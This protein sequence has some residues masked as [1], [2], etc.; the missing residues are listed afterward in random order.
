MLMFLASSGGQEI[1]IGKETSRVA[2]LGSEY[3]IDL[4]STSDVFLKGH[5]IRLEVPF[6]NFPDSDRELNTG[7][8]AAGG[9][10]TVHWG[11]Q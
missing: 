6:S 5:R 10:A 3:R 8:S 7:A 9:G 11:D 4:W 1:G 2:D